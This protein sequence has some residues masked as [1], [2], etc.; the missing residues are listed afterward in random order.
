M[1]FFVSNTGSEVVKGRPQIRKVGY[2]TRNGLNIK[3]SVCLLKVDAKLQYYGLL[4][5]KL[6]LINRNAMFT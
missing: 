3:V 6:H 4:T 2:G 5:V 1:H